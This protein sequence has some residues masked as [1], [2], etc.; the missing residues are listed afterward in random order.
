MKK[1]ATL[2]VATEVVGEKTVK[3]NVE[4]VETNDARV[5]DQT[6][7]PQAQAP[8][9]VQAPVV[10]ES[11]NPTRQIRGVLDDL[12]REEEGEEDSTPLRAH[13]DLDIECALAT[14][15]EEQGGLIPTEEVV[16]SE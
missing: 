4:E 8:I 10:V 1:P 6:T 14:Q 13:I 9:P 5:E 3:E 7:P 15:L 2:T 12:H 16:G 11:S